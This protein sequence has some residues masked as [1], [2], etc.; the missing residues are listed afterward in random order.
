V[1]LSKGWRG[2]I[3]FSGTNIKEYVGYTNSSGDDHY[4][5]N[6]YPV[7]NTNN[8]TTDDAANISVV[9]NRSFENASIDIYVDN[10]SMN[11]SGATGFLALNFSHGYP[12]TLEVTYNYR[13]V[14]GYATGI[15]FAIDNAP[16]GAFCIGARTPAEVLIGNKGV[17]GT[18]AEFF[19]DR[20]AFKRAYGGDVNEGMND[21]TIEVD[22]TGANVSF[23]MTGVKVGGWSMDHTQDAIVAQNCDF[24]AANVSL[25]SD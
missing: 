14:V 11:V 13:E 15:N 21:I 1:T 17:T 20:R 4:L 18:I 7:V 2:T 5:L 6:Q 16:E 24:T 25:Y 22:E 8:S 12:V 3:V 19:A 9:L 10:T 23:K